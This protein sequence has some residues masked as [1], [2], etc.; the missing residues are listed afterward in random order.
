MSVE[1]REEDSSVGGG[2]RGPCGMRR[3]DE[4]LERLGRGKWEVEEKR[5]KGPLVV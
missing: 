2:G 3:R 4:R 1:E 5:G